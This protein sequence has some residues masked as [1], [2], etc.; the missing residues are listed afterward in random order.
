V[1]QREYQ[2]DLNDIIESISDIQ[3]FTAGM[4][5]TTFIQDKKTVYAVIR[6]I[7]VIG[8]ASKNIPGNGREKYR[9]FHGS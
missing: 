8:E 5:F 4:D 1:K 2:D 3:S 9:F 6:C 7:E